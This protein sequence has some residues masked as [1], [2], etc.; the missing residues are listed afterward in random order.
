[1]RNLHPQRNITNEIQRAMEN[2]SFNLLI[3]DYHDFYCDTIQKIFDRSEKMPV[4]GRARSYGEVVSLMSFHH[5][6]ILLLDVSVVMKDQLE[7]VAVL[8][9]MHPETVIAALTLFE[10]EFDN[11]LLYRYGF[12][13]VLSRFEDPYKLIQELEEACLSNPEHS[14]RGGVPAAA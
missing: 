13:R 14:P 2:Q 3:A 5:P 11:M 6:D 4:I 12:D 10:N 8:K 9:K 7:K 1:M